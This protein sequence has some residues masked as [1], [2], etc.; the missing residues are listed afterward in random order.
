MELQDTNDIYMTMNIAILSDDVNFNSAQ[1]TL[2]FIDGVIENKEEYVGIPFLVNREKIENGDY[3]NLTHELNTETG[4]LGTDQIGSF[5]DFWKDE[6]DGAN[7]LMGSIKIFKRFSQTCEAI[8]TLVTDNSLETSCEVLI[9]EYQEINEDGVRKIH[10][11]DGKNSLFGSSIVTHGAEFRAKPTLLIAEAYQKDITLEQKGGEKLQKE[12]EYNN[13]IKVELQS[14]LELFSLRPYEIEQQIYNITN[15]VDA[16]TGNREYNYYI[17]TLYHDKAILESESA[18]TLYSANY[19]VESDTVILDS[20][21]NWKKGSFQFVP[22]GVSV[23]ELMEHNTDKIQKLSKELNGLK[24]EKEKMSKKKDLTVEELNEKIDGLETEIANLKETNSTLEETIVS[25][26][27]ASV[28][29]EK[30]VSELN[31]QIEGLKGYKEQVETAEKEAKIAELNA[32]YSKILSEETFKAENTIK[33]INEL[34]EVELNSLVVAEIAKQK[35]AEVETASKEEED[36]VIT[37]S[38]QEDLVTVEKDASY[39]NSPKE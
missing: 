22:E 24:E 13:G 5:V 9:K 39:W 36:V 14:K 30:V 26:K 23:N 11:N 12:K 17:H 2:D 19:K 15:P 28:K 6:I 7:C 27:E 4:E 31:E 25:Q 29:S 34:N 10:Y 3:D 32:K 33:L 16:K 20:N 1:F 38:K 35:I 8:T 37:A 18:Y 21:E